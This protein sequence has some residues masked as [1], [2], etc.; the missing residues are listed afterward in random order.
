VNFFHNTVGT[1]GNLS[2]SFG[3]AEQVWQTGVR[4][5]LSEVRTGKGPIKLD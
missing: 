5:N 1:E 4:V 3:S 2:T